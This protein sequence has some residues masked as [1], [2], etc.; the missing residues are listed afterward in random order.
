ML[1]KMKDFFEY[2]ITQ[3]TFAIMGFL[4]M[5]FLYWTF[6]LINNYFNKK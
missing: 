6:R 4:M 1:L 2:Y 5:A 3:E